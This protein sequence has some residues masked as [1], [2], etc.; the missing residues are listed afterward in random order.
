MPKQEITREQ[1]DRLIEDATYL[2]DEAEA[3]KYV[4]DEVPYTVNPPEGRSI[5]AMLLF[6]DFSQ[7]NYYRP[8]LEKAIEDTRPTHIENFKDFEASFEPDEEKMQDIQKIL[9]KLSKHRAW[10]VNTT[11]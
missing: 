9:S 5:A 6:I 4:I 3:L 8:I 2:Q 1:V 11:V 7:M 10:V